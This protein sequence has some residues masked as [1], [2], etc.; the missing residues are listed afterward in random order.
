MTPTS[1]KALRVYAASAGSGKTHRLVL[2]YLKIL[3]TDANYRQKFKHIVAMTFTNKAANEMKGRILQTL[4]G[5]AYPLSANAK[6]MA[7]KADL[8]RETELKETELQARAAGAL[9]GILH[10]YEDFNISTIDKFNLRLIRSFSRD[11]DISADFEVVLNEKIVLEEVIDLLFARLGEPDSE[12]LTRWMLAYA[13]TKV[14]EGESWD[15][16]NSLL[17]F[18]EVLGKERNNKD[19][20]QLLSSTFLPEEY[21]QFKTASAKIKAD[22][23]ARCA[24]VYEIASTFIGSHFKNKRDQKRIEDLLETQQLGPR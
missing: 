9:Q 8:I 19:V 1:S 4:S 18:S 24:E 7:L 5:L 22:F 3:L 23:M 21:E 2:E 12:E 10:H 14:A 15:F 16:K 6:T 20:T 13:K 17:Q 11:L